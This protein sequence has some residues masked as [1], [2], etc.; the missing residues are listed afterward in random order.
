MA[1]EKEIEREESLSVDEETAGK[2]TV[3]EETPERERLQK[4]IAE[5][6]YCSRRKAEE[7]IQKGRVTV[8]GKVVDTLGE[9]VS[10]DAH[11][12][13]DGTPLPTKEEMESRKVYIAVYKPLGFICSAFDPQHRRLITELIPPRYGRV[14]PVGRLDI[15]S[16]GLVFMTNDGEFAN[17]ITHPSSSPE[18][19][20]EVKI[21]TRLTPQQQEEL[22][23]GIMLEDGMT[24]PCQVKEIAFS[25]SE[26]THS[27]N[28]V[29]RITLT[30]GRNRE[31]RRMMQYF[32]KNVLTLKRTQIGMVKLGKLRKGSYVV[33]P[34]PIVQRIMED[35]RLRKM[36]NDYRAPRKYGQ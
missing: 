3:D 8:D 19:V 18:K 1:D 17:L 11:I 28:G 29:Y 34:D 32:G 10:P 14:Y 24:A 9:T 21:D 27:I 22:R 31:V 33:L 12:E 5:R 35:C 16:E 30:E 20:Y 2:E 36:Q 4:V 6:G 26:V 15:N 13:I 25:L 7:L 23:N